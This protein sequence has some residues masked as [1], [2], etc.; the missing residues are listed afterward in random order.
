MKSESM[1]EMPRVEDFFLARQPIL[2]RDQALVAY[3]LLFRRAGYGEADVVDDLSATATVI[4][5]ASELGMDQV[6][7]G[8]LGFFNVDAAVLMSDIVTFL[9]PD[10]PETAEW[11]RSQPVPA[12]CRPRQSARDWRRV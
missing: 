4:A 10:A 8:S 5:H 12:L 6:I 11:R 1:I 9:P 7:G 3:E 2:D